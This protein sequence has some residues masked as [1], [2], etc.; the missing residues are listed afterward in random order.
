MDQRRLDYVDFRDDETRAA[1]IDDAP[2]PQPGEP[3]P[4]ERQTIIALPNQ[5]RQTRGRPKKFIQRQGENKTNVKANLSQK[6]HLGALFSRHGDEKTLE[7]YSS[8]CRIPIGNTKTLLW[9]LRRGESILPK[10]HYKRKSRVLP[11][12]HLVMRRLTLDPTTP[13]RE[14]REDLQLIVARHG[15]DL[16]NIPVNVVDEIVAEKRRV[17]DEVPMEEVD[18]RE[19][20]ERGVETDED[21]QG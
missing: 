15:E 6:V 14:V 9:K 21:E 20:E 1:Y 2:Q 3:L 10:D 8:Q 4:E 5:P 11:F 17:V 13:L 7:W 16:E 18:M 19:A 12:Q